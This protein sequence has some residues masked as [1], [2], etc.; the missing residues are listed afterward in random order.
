M[1]TSGELIGPIVAFSLA[2]RFGV[3]GKSK[4]DLIM[5]VLALIAIGWLVLAEGTLF[6]LVLALIADGI[7]LTLTIRKL[8]ID[9]ASESRWVWGIFALSGTFAILSLT[10]LT[11]ETLVFPLYVIAG[12]SY[13]AWR[14]HPSKKHNAE[15]K[16]L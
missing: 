10:T 8:H 15:L 14:A 9:P 7:A 3:G 1:F 11:V 5:L 6:S 2:L 13:I 12:S 16:K 4:F